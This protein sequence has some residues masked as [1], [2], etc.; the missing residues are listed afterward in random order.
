MVSAAACRDACAQPAPAGTPEKRIAL[1][2]GDESYAAG[3]LPTAANDAGLIAQTLQAAGF[4]VIGARDLDAE[5]LR[6]S[7]KDFLKRVMDAGPDTL[8][9]VTVVQRQTSIHQN[10][11]IGMVGTLVHR[12]LVCLPFLGQASSPLLLL[13]RRLQLFSPRAKSIQTIRPE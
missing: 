13:S 4:E 2:I 9:F 10:A 12:L 5:T 8:A 6:Q 1:V 7:Y 3:A 11:R